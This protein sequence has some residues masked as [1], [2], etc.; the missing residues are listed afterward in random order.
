MLPSFCV[1]IDL[2]PPA[3]SSKSHSA[4][5]SVRSWRNRFRGS[6][7]PAFQ[8]RF[9]STWSDVKKP[10]TPPEAEVISTTSF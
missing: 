7:Q 3:M 4:G 10:S 6:Y 2:A 5:V 9:F 1:M 8:K